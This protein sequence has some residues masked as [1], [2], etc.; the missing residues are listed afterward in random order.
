MTETEKQPM[1]KEKYSEYLTEGPSGTM[2]KIM[3]RNN[4]EEKNLKH[5]SGKEQRDG[6]E[7]IRRKK[8][9]GPEL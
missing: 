7:T 4:V 9:S 3:L 5:Q 2:E 1:G 8:V 6:T